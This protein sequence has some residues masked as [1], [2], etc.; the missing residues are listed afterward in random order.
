[1]SE[2]PSD[3]AANRPLSPHAWSWRWHLT[4]LVS[5]LH[6]ATGMAL[7]AGAVLLAGW[8]LALAIGP[9]AY[10]GFRLVIGSPLGKLVL[11]GLTYSLFFHLANG[12]RHL[13]WDF[14]A[15]FQLKAAD[16]GA[17]AVIAFAAAATAGVWLAAGLMGV[18]A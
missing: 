9:H 10:D 2:A 15:G 1:M 3:P 5:I 16:A 12:I 17:V 4:M 11:F 18:L 7:Y 13:I 14:G 8:A 6:R